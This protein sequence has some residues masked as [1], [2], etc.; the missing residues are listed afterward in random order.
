MKDCDGNDVQVGDRVRVLE[1]YQH[2]LGASAS[3]E[4]ADKPLCQKIFEIHGIDE[5]GY[6]YVVKRNEDDDGGSSYVGIHLRPHE[7]RV[8]WS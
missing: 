7:F 1:Q 3:S 8:Y 2:L 6:V 5:S 4:P